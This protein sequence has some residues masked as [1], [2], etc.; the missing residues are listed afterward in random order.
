MT[1]DNLGGNQSLGF[2]EGF[3]ATYYCRICIC[4]KEDCKKMT[5]DNISLYRNRENYANSLEKIKISQKAVL[6]ET[7]GIHRDC[8]LNKLKYFHILDNYNV[9]IM[10]DLM[11][12]TCASLLSNFF[13]YGI[14]NCIFSEDEIQTSI[15]YYDYGILNSHNIPSKLSLGRK[16]L[17]Q[18]ASQ[19]KCLMSNIPYIFA[20][21]K[22]NAFFSRV[23]PCIQSML[24][25]IKIVYSSSI[26]END[27]KKLEQATH[28]HL[29]GMIK[30]FNT[31]L[32]PKHHFMVHYANIIRLKGPIVHMSTMRYETKHKAFTN[33]ARQTN[34]F[35]NLS[36][37][38][39]VSY[40]TTAYLKKSYVNE[41]QTT[42][43]QPVSPSCLRKYSEIFAC[44][45]E[46]PEKLLTIKWLKFNSNFYT[47]GL[48]ITVDSIF[49]EIDDIFISEDNHYFICTEFRFVNFDKYLNS[50][51]IQKV[52]PEKKRLIQHKELSYKK[53]MAKRFAYNGQIFI[54]L[55]SL[56]I[57]FPNQ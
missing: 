39:A 9:D 20:P 28:D 33:I 8:E 48:L 34:N 46:N 56:E 47:Q 26:T 22:D 14:S 11:E 2:S 51:Q 52:F 43:K 1:F 19:M 41:I 37:T 36:K 27:L 30:C 31:N 17:G 53:S 15:Q 45:F 16:N 49:Y 25:I 44:S 12:G 35:V 50:I 32:T 57:G 55:D 18:N 40:Q 38:L 13:D 24:V 42:V 5:R 3:N 21:Y 7:Q 23:W 6:K 54:I 29:S 10:H 4:M